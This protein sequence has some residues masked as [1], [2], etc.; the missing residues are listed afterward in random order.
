MRIGKRLWLLMLVGLSRVLAKEGA[1]Y[2]IIVQSLCPGGVDTEF[3]QRMR[4]D[5]PKKEL[6]KPEDCARA[7]CFMLEMPTSAVIDN[8]DLRR[9]RSSSNL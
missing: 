9:W 1:P 5:I 8:I 6:I 4:P 3:V 7:V 2:N